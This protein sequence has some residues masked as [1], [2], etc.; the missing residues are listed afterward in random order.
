MNSFD[1]DDNEGALSQQQ[2]SCMLF[3]KIR[4]VMSSINRDIIIRL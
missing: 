4:N 2:F 1:D 3:S